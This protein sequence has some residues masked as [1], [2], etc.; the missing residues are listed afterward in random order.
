MSN[1]KNLGCL[2]FEPKKEG[3]QNGKTDSGSVYWDCEPVCRSR[4]HPTATFLFVLL[5]WLPKQKNKKLKMFC[6]WKKYT[7]CDLWGFK[8]ISLMLYL[9]VRHNETRDKCILALRPVRILIV[10]LKNKAAESAQKRYGKCLL[11]RF[12]WKFPSESYLFFLRYL[13]FLGQ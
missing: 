7:R 5:F 1:Y 13:L 2:N 9:P 6:I 11:I 8:H 4:L 3:W 12:T 10:V